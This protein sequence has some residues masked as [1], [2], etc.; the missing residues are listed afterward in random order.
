MAVADTCGVQ[1]LLWDFMLVMWKQPNQL[2]HGKQTIRHSMC[3]WGA[4]ITQGL[5]LV[6]NYG[7]VKM[8]KKYRGSDGHRGE[9]DTC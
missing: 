3:C 9:S 4:Q 7:D 1:H 8:Y 2:I 5:M 6:S